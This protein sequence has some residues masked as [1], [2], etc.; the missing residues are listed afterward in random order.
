MKSGG[1][2][3]KGSGY[4]REIAKFLT[5][6]ITGSEKPYCFW[7]SPSS[8]ALATISA[9]MDASGDIIPI[10]DEGKFLTNLF[11]I[12]IKTGY[13]HADFFQHFKDMKNDVIKA[14]W[15][16]CCTDAKKADK[17]PM[18]IFKKSG[19][20]PIIGINS[21]TRAELSDGYTILP[22]SMM[23]V[24]DD[25]TQSIIFYDMES[26]FKVVTPEHIRKI[27]GTT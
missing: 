19:L 9:A 27:G 4:E 22:K 26:F 6:W 21:I 17:Y 25:G 20:K 15:I 2:K 8:G 23:I 7:R 3:A 10:R 18:L 1:G 13:P 24:Y 5:K 11:S 12:E 14:F 16:Q